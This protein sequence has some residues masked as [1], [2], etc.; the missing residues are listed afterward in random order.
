MV[1]VPSTPRY[2]KDSSLMR[3]DSRLMKLLLQNSCSQRVWHSRV[4]MDLHSREPLPNS[5][6]F[7]MSHN[8]RHVDPS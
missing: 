4:Y 7:V 8:T 3:L 6:F 5:A 2:E 1:L